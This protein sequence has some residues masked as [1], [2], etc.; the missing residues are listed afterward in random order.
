MCDKMPS[1]SQQYRIETA[2]K[3][4]DEESSS[5]EREKKKRLFLR[6]VY[7][8]SMRLQYNNNSIDKTSHTFIETNAHIRVAP[9]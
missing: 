9:L 6:Y 2:I 4:D 8:S 7:I 5:R 3:I 1:A